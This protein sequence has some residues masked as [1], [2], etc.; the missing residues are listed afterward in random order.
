MYWVWVIT[1]EKS[2]EILRLDHP[3]LAVLAV[4]QHDFMA[5]AR[6]IAV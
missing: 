6:F 5:N 1:A 4:R 3:W 2:F